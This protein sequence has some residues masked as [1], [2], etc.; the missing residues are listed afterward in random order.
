MN[1]WNPKIV[2][3]HQMLLIIIIIIIMAE[4]SSENLVQRRIQAE[5][6]H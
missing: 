1:D 6:E 3:C 4:I 2:N 5:E